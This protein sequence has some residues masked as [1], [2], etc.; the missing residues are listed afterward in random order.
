MIIVI[1]FTIC[2]RNLM[3]MVFTVLL[4]TSKRLNIW[5][6]REWCMLIK[7][8]CLVGFLRSNKEHGFLAGSGCPVLTC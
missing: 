4:V 1:S 8:R 2:F 6:L 5:Y 3:L 7:T